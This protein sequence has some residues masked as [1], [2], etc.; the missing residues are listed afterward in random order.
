MQLLVHLQI[1]VDVMSQPQSRN[2]PC[3]FLTGTM[4]EEGNF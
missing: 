3:R 2:P 1:P 4:L